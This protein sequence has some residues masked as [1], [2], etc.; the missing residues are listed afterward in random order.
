MN[1]ADTNNRVPYFAVVG[2]QAVAVLAAEAVIATVELVEQ[3]G[4]FALYCPKPETRRFSTNKVAAAH[5]HSRS[6]LIADFAKI[7]F[8]KTGKNYSFRYLL[9]HNFDIEP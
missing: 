1:S 4:I 3:V 7:S 8:R 9:V 2:G 5:T 6:S